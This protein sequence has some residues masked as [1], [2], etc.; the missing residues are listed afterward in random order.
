MHKEHDSDEIFRFVNTMNWGSLDKLMSSHIKG[1]RQS[2]EGEFLLAPPIIGW[3]EYHELPPEESNTLKSCYLDG[4][5]GFVVGFREAGSNLPLWCSLTS[6]DCFYEDPSH[7]RIA[8][9]QGCTSQ[10]DSPFR[11]SSV[12]RILDRYDWEAVSVLLIIDLAQYLHFPQ[13]EVEPADQ[14]HPHDLGYMTLEKAQQRYDGTASRCGFA[15]GS[16]GFFILHLEP[17][18]KEVSQND[19]LSCLSEVKSNSA[20]VEPLTLTM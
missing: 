5:Y 2:L 17:S 19:K 13:V 7:I 11:R 12:R 18:T 4:R 15:R 20:L 16:G 10:W 14:K 3:H 9:L 8:Q 1:K 6:F